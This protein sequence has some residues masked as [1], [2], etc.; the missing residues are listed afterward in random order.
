M[1]NRG[2]QNDDAR[3]YDYQL[4]D[5]GNLLAR[6]PAIDLSKPYFSA[7]G[8][9]QT[10]GRF[11]DYP[12]PSALGAALDI[13]VLNLGMSGAGPSFFLERSHL[14][15]LINK[16][17]FAIIQMFSARSLSNTYAI[18]GANQGTLILRCEPDQPA[19]FAEIVYQKLLETLSPLDLVR[20]R[21]E[22]RMVY[23]S[24]MKTLLERIKVP[25]ILLYWST[26][27]PNYRE[28]T[29]DLSAYWGAFPHFVNND[30]VH[31]LSPMADEI[32]EVVGD[33]GLP[34]PLFE[35]TT[36]KP[37]EMWSAEKFPN[38]RFR[39]SNLYYPSPEM[40]A[41]AAEIL[42][43]YCKRVLGGSRMTDK[44][45]AQRQ[46]P[47]KVLIHF[48]IFKNAGTTIDRSLERSFGQRLLK[49]DAPD[50]SIALRF[51]DLVPR[52]PTRVERTAV[53]CHQ[54][55]F[56]FP[57]EQDLLSFPLL[58]LRHPI[59]RAQSI[60]DYERMDGR[61]GT[62]NSPHT[63][64][65][66]EVEFADWV[67]WC[68]SSQLQ[69]G[70]ISNYQTRVC[71]DVNNGAEFDH[72]KEK[73]ALENLYQALQNLQGAQVGIVE[74]F[75]SS[76]VRIERALK[77]DFPEL[78]LL[79]FVENANDG[80]LKPPSR[81]IEEVR[82]RLGDVTFRRLCE[83]NEFDMVLYEQMGGTI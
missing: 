54:I 2:Y 67:E 64:K 12:F 16:G 14:I 40:N 49:I 13:Q 19:Q 77:N 53:S 63:K 15:E 59:L 52:L 21:V 47:R 50:I 1:V 73:V 25:K 9:A 36:G 51:S 20:L 34:Q 46:L 62:S 80:S 28:A 76:L 27:T 35:K 55:R 18:T 60:Y 29:T 82:H 45:G 17:R 74:D 66:N 70:P 38:I 4:W 42:L 3:L 57:A 39:T 43:P 56:P 68:L 24:E 79:N 33:A 23:I 32:V 81:R 48:H 26:R 5:I 71:S 30:V 6:G 11:V 22:N 61:A 65:A 69:S 44:H 75:Q 31:A 7:V 72:W 58:F 83:A 78:S 41:Q 37:F 10:F 8:A